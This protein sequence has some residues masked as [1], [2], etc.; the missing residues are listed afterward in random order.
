MSKTIKYT[1]T[2]DEYKI[3][4]HEALSKGMTVSGY[5]KTA[6]FAHAS[7]YPAKG[8]FSVLLDTDVRR[9]DNT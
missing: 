1:V 9:D 8:I 4:E 3:L 2:N 6:V 5:T 7:K